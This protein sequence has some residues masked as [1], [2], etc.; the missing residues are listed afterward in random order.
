MKNPF[1]YTLTAMLMPLVVACSLLEPNEVESPNIAENTFLESV[2]AMD[3]WVNGTEK[4]WALTVGKFCLH[5]EII[6]D[7]YFNNYTRESKVFDIPE[8]LNT[9]PDISELQRSIATLRESADYGIN[10]VQQHDKQTTREHLLKLH[11]IKA[12]AFI[13]A[14]EN[15]MAL[16]VEEGGEVKEWQEQLKRALQTLETTLQYAATDTDKAFIHTLKARTYYRLGN[17]DKAL[18]ASKEALMLSKD[19]VKQVVFD[20]EN[21]VCNAIQDDIWK[22][23]YQPLPRLDFLDPKYFQLKSTDEQPICIA[24][25]EENHLI[26]AE[27]LLVKGQTDE[28]KN[29][30][31]KLLLLIAQRPIHKALNDQLEGRFNGGFKHYPDNSRYVVAASP[32]DEYRKGLVLDRKKPNLIDV[33]TISGTSVTAQMIDRGKNTDDLLELVYLLRQEVFMAEGRRMNDLGIRLPLSEVEIGHTKTATAYAKAQIPEFIPLEQGMDAF[34]MDTKNYRVTIKY[35]M[36]KIIV[37]NKKSAF[38]APFFNE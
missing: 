15:F 27:A 24:K 10:I 4:A 36:N 18:A 30:L 35:N 23:M 32:E 19:L 37:K 31:K 7:N 16:P 20:G 22:T 26:I 9:D 11:T 28:C 25:A 12:Y 8:L 5:T 1:K 3:T 29:E 34:D 21:N 6:S 2:N 14:G 17:A 33:P 38:V 13:L